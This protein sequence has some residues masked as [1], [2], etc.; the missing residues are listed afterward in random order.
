MIE[1][2]DPFTFNGRRYT[3]LDRGFVGLLVAYGQ[4]HVVEALDLLGMT[5]IH[6]HISSVRNYCQRIEDSYC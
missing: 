2:I 6:Y 1:L 3:R 5:P 4:A